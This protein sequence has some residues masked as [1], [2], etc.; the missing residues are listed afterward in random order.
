MSDDSDSDYIVEHYVKPDKISVLPVNDESADILGNFD[1][2]KKKNIQSNVE[3]NDESEYEYASEEEES[4]EDE[5]DAV[6][7]IPSAKR[8]AVPEDGEDEVKKPKKSKSKKLDKDGNFSQDLFSSL[9]RGVSKANRYVLYVTNLNFGTSK[10][11][12]SEYFST[13]GPVKTVR[14]PKKRKGGFAFVEMEDIAGFQV[15]TTLFHYQQQ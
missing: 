9:L 10:E 12:L 8:K 7:D 2:A 1:D 6:I 11:R 4:E 5:D 14:I 3:E 13:A 15:N